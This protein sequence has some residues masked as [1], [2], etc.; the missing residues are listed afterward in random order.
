MHCSFT[1]HHLSV[2]FSYC[3]ETNFTSTI[4]LTAYFF[5][6]SLLNY[7]YY[8][9]LPKYLQSP[10]INPQQ[11]T[12]IKSQSRVLIW[13]DHWCLQFR[14]NRLQVRRSSRL[15]GPLSRRKLSTR[16][17]YLSSL[18]RRRTSTRSRRAVWPW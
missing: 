3:R 2:L 15:K 16:K 12:L 4:L 13:H 9:E 7:C 11:F 17:L 10:I 18:G 8:I 14:S 1:E 5:I 6:F